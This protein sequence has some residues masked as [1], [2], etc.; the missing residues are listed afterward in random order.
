MIPNTE[1][2]REEYIT[3]DGPWMNTEIKDL[4]NKT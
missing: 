3:I 2:L 1:M 4:K